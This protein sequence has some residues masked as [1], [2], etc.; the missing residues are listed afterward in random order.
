MTS[1][2]PQRTPSLDGCRAKLSRAEDHVGF[3]TASVQRSGLS[4]ILV[5]ETAL[6]AADQTLRVTAPIRSGPDLP[7]QWSLPIG[8][9]IPNLRAALHYLVYELSALEGPGGYW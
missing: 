4:V 3:V 6:E 7:S 1:S 9:A 8:D 2:V 5:Q